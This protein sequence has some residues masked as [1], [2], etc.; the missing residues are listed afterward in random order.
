MC[1]HHKSSGLFD[2]ENCQAPVSSDDV[3]YDSE[4]NWC[5][6]C[7]DEYV[8]REMAHLWPLYQ[9]EKAM[10]LLDEPD[11]PVWRLK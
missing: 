2:C 11:E 6:E 4:N 10:G 8:N 5:P 9:A 7:R 1:K 3:G